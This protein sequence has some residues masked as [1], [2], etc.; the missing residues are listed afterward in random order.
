MVF[1]KL[2]G[3]KMKYVSSLLFGILVLFSVNS[4]AA[5]LYHMRGVQWDYTYYAGYNHYTI[6]RAKFD[7]AL[8]SCGA[9]FDLDGA[10][11]WLEFDGHVYGGTLIAQGGFGWY[12]VEGWEPNY[13]WRVKVESKPGQMSAVYLELTGRPPSALL[14]NLPY[15]DVDLDV[16][17][18]LGFET[19]NM[20]DVSVDSVKTEWAIDSNATE[21]ACLG[22]ESVKYIQVWNEWGWARSETVLRGHVEW[23]DCTGAFGDNVDGEPVYITLNSSLIEIPT[24]LTHLFGGWHRYNFPGGGHFKLDV[25][26][27][28]YDLK[29]YNDDLDWLD[30][31]AG[32]DVVVEV[33]D[34]VGFEF[35]PAVSDLGDLPSRPGQ[36]NLWS[37]TYGRVCFEP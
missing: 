35:I 15:I 31:S 29:Y 30:V 7:I 13:S 4:K 17:N 12:M 19:L 36:S 9:F 37:D 3:N 23:G 18:N 26:N 14:V 6:I 32:V 10:D 33:G 25:H 11:V 28:Y 27:G 22:T 8:N 21:M 2:K 1:D 24:G 5:D 34:R 20:V 16:D